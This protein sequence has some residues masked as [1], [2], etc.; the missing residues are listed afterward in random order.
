V[1]YMQEEIHQ[2]AYRHQ[3]AVEAGERAVVGVNAFTEDE[4]A[5][6]IPQPDYSALEAGQ[7]ERLEAFKARR[8]AGEVGNVLD[9]VRAA[10]RNGENLM[11]RFVAAVKGGATLGEISDALRTEWGTY[12]GH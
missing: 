5:P 12:D 10:A 11:P 1:E 4:P 9:A 7:K 8:D 3:L 6:H 2:A